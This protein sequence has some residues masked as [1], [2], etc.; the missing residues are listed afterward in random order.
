M[1]CE[2]KMPVFMPATSVP[3]RTGGSS[4][5]PSEFMLSD[6]AW[7]TSS[8]PGSS[9]FGPFSPNGL[10]V[11][12]EIV[13]RSFRNER[14]VCTRYTPYVS[15]NR[16]VPGRLSLSTAA[17]SGRSS[18]I[19]RD[20]QAAERNLDFAVLWEQICEGDDRLASD[21]IDLLT[22][23]ALDLFADDLTITEVDA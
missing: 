7:T 16:R 20:G 17:L 15:R 8:A 11:P 4:D 6:I 2:A 5:R 10:T 23:V 19:I 14:L 18:G 1:A 12:A 13:D 3:M 21:D 22:T 9:R